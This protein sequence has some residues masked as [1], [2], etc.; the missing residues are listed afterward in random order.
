M[1]VEELVAYFRLHIVEIRLYWSFF[2]FYLFC[3]CVCVNCDGP[4][5]NEG[6][7]TAGRMKVKTLLQSQFNFN[8]ES[9]MFEMILMFDL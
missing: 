1:N 7:I 6:K 2:I 3:V 4:V 8:N 5:R 9:N